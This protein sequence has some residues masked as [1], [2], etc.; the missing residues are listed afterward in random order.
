[1]SASAS[2]LYD[3]WLPLEMDSNPPVTET[4]GPTETP[5][6]AVSGPSEE[7]GENEAEA[8]VG[9]LVAGKISEPSKKPLYL[10]ADTSMKTTGTSGLGQEKPGGR[11]REAALTL[12]RTL[13]A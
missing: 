5:P 7:E 6:S 3:T 8:E 9:G 2:F 10:L 1:M 11:G 4:E 13:P 12:D